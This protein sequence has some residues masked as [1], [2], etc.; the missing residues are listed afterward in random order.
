MKRML[1]NA[2]H[3]E[4]L[5]VAVVD[6]QKLLD[7]DIETAGNE[8]KK[9]NIYKGKISR[10]EPGLE[11][12]FV[13]YGVP[14]HGFL[15]FKEILRSIFKDKNVDFSKAKIK[16]VIEEGQELLVQV[17]KDERGNKGAA[18]TTFIGLAGRYLVLMPNNP[19]GGGVS[20][21]IE[22]N[23]RESLKE[24][25]NQL[26]LPNGM[27]IIARTAGIGRSLDELKW[28][29]NYLLQLWDAIKDASESQKSPFLIFQDGSLVIRA[30]RDYFHQDIEEIL[31][32][33]KN[34]YEQAY[35]F[36]SN[37]MPDNA[38]RVKLYKETTPLFSRFQIEQQIE[39]AF[40]REVTL[41][42]GGSIVIDHTEAMVTVDVNSA[43]STR[44]SD[45]EETAYKT[46]KEA[47]EEISR[48][49]R[50]RDIGGLIV[51]DFIDMENQKNQRLIEEQLKNLS[52]IDRAR[53]QIGR[54]SRFGL[55]ELS[56][57]RL[58]GV[59]GESSNIT[60]PRCSGIGH[61]RSVE[62]SALH[63][64]RAME[65]ESMKDGTVSIQA[66]VPLTVAAYLLNEKR[67]EIRY[68]EKRL[69][70]TCV[71]IPN[72]NLETP[73][74]SIKRV[75][76]DD[77][78]N[79]EKPSY[80]ILKTIEKESS[81][82]S[83]TNKNQKNSKPIVTVVNPEKAPMAKFS[84]ISFFKNLFSPKKSNKKN[85]KFTNK[86][87]YLKSKKY[88]KKRENYQSK[89]NNK[90]KFNTK[91]N[92]KRS[93]KSSPQST[94]NDHETSVDATHTNIPEPKKDINHLKQDNS[95]INEINSLIEATSNDFDNSIKK[96][97]N[98]ASVNASNIEKNTNLSEKKVNYKE[99]IKESGFE[100][101]ETKE[102]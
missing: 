1:F 72:T 6:G 73:N 51:V 55:L 14:R 33:E 11:A 46:N 98:K 35:Q 31:I 77:V 48:Q 60:C 24:V 7:L 81:V 84:I 93:F 28:D 96:L 39:S 61:I 29:L 10:I 53:I 17:E 19:R 86:R 70:V 54:I 43:R 15:P 90:R 3:S 94:K 87:K 50:I 80:T 34:I 44:G 26:E 37:V 45:I 42:S 88:N 16:D 30:I 49:L 75:K 21:R 66:Q 71:L 4:E 83:S 67:V 78:E 12:A 64:L 56:R 100:M 95:A 57:Q 58:R 85:S 2:T 41:P 13:D 5:R 76:S 38:A 97:S 25:I 91:R 74:Y 40:S 62:S 99:V 63:I 47:A 32:D 68:L 9:S 36:M 82:N 101:I 69:G 102:K 79:N 20:R 52:L 23:E 92:F 65:E 27:S 22:G 18:L 59:L 8:K 89:N